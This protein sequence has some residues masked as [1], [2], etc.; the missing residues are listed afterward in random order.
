MR[1]SPQTPTRSRSRPGRVGLA[2]LPLALLAT[3]ALWGPV[4][5]ADP[6]LENRID[7]A[8]TEAEGLE[9]RIAAQTA[10]VATLSEQ[11]RQAG[12]R[13]M[14]LQAQIERITAR[15]NQL[16]SQL[17]ELEKQLAE[18][19]ARLKRAIAVL[20]ER[21]VEIYK[22]SEPDYLT[23]VMEADGFDDLASRTELIEALRN[24]DQR[25]AE[26]VRALRDEV[27]AHRDQIAA[28]KAQIDEQARRLDAARGEALA[29]RAEAESRIAELERARA[30]QQA[31]LKRVQGDIAGLEDQLAE[32][33]AQQQAEQ[34]AA[35]AP[36][37]EGGPYAIPTYIVM[38]ESGGNYAAL[39][40][41]SGAG[42]AYQILP[43]TWRAY[44][45]SGPPHQASKAEQDRIAGLI[46]ADVGPSAW[47]C[48]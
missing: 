5:A 4:A 47:S 31:S 35:D 3:A 48:A 2:A 7:S 44:G 15:S 29:A 19:Q 33:L 36:A 17:A 8:R 40:P 11:A 12:A 16:A 23:V 28:L 6:E 9:E 1:G 38:C 26:R 20:S 24:A 42:G 45:G 34:Q 43:S 46:W 13:E 21:L 41:S 39:N 32:Q 22:G 37:F 14:Q 18:V 30:A 27:E 10:E 25:L